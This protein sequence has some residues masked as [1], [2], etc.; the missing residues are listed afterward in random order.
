MLDTIDRA[1]IRE[2]QAIRDSFQQRRPRNGRC[3]IR[4]T[5]KGVIKDDLMTL[6]KREYVQTQLRASRDCLPASAVGE[7]P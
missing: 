2:G 7:I 5:V 3:N 4:H 6:L 1:A